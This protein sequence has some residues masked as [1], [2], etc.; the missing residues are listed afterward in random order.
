[1][2]HGS[3]DNTPW[4]TTYHQKV[5]EQEDFSLVQSKFLGLIWVWNLEEPA[6]ADQ[7]PVG[8]GEHLWWEGHAAVSRL[9]SPG[10]WTAWEPSPKA[11]HW[12]APP[13]TECAG[14]NVR[15]GS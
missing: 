14:L 13:P 6:V 8:Q 10:A 3:Q 15:L 11:W 9:P 5:V 2:Y 7:P 12:N 1:M 4:A